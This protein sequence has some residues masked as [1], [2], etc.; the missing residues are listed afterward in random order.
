MKTYVVIYK[1]VLSHTFYV[2]ANNENE[3]KKKF[4][5]TQKSGDFDYSSGKI[6]NTTTEV[7]EAED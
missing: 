4:E 7:Y 3:A 6:V 1:E 5:E 2:E